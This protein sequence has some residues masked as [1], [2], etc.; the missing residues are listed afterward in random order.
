M[1]TH[2]ELESIILDLRSRM[3]RDLRWLAD[4]TENHPEIHLSEILKEINDIHD[5]YLK[6]NHQL[7]TALRLHYAT[8]KKEPLTHR[9]EIDN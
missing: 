7:T 6:L 2:K 8:Q 3:T 5:N 9:T 1:E 4:I